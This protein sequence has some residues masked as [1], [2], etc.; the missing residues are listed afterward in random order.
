LSYGVF[1]S[2]SAPEIDDGGRFVVTA[3]SAPQ[4]V[5]KVEATFKEE[6]AR[7]LKD[8]FTA[9]EVSAAKTAWL[10]QRMVGRTE[11]SSLVVTLT[12]RERFD[13]TLKWDEAL[14]AKVAALTPDQVNQ[15]FRRHLDLSALTIIRA[16]DFKKA[17]V[18]Q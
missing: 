9:D 18:Y 17:G 5:P 15:A 16:G 14:E 2:F 4:N 13:R 8:G 3:I 11:E 1:S 10:E 6:L 12:Q 7:A